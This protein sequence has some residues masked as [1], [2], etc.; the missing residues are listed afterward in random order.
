[1]K[2]RH[3]HGLAWPRRDRHEQIACELCDAIQ[4]APRLLEGE[5]AHCGHCGEMLFQ[6]R[7]RSLSRAIGFSAAALIFMALAHSFP[8]LTMEAAGNRTELG[9]VEAAQA[10][11]EDGDAPLAALSIGFTVVAPLLLVGGLLYIAAPLSVGKAW[12][13]SVTLAR[14]IQHSE[15]WSMLEVFLLGFIVSL[16]KLGHLADIEFHIGLWALVAVVLCIA[17]AIGGIDRRE[18]WDRL[19]LAQLSRPERAPSPARPQ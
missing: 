17:G 1:M 18:L 3:H 9:L 2:R 6:N 10:L 8:F 11:L 15:P 16:L 4:E 19:E 13:G 5:I 14:W 7:T 12:P